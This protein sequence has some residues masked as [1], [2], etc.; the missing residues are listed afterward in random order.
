MLFYFNFINPS[1]TQISKEQAINIIMDEVVGGSILDFNIYLNKDKCG[2]EKFDLT[3]YDQIIN[4]Y[5]TS[6]LFF[7]DLMPEYGWGHPCKYVFIQESSGD[8]AILDKCIPPINYLN[9]WEEVSVTYPHQFYIQ[10]IDTTQMDTAIVS[11]DPHKYA[12]LI[13]WWAWEDIARWNNLS[14]VYTGLKKTYGFMDENIFVLSDDGIYPDSLNLNLDGLYPINDFDGPCTKEKIEEIFE[15]LDSVMT[16]VDIFLFYATTHGDTTGVGLDTTS[17]R[18][19][20]SQPLWD[21][22]LEEMVNNLTCSEMIFCLD[23]CNGGGIVMV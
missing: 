2:S 22:E 12:L 10:L 4:P 23:I 7:I 1:Y 9:I 18:L 20:D 17:F 14:H 21:Y 15:H 6:W 16:E 3:P 19:D 13:T 8:Y 11:P 5:D